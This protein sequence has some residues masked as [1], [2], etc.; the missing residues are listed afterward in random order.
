LDEKPVHQA[1]VSFAEVAAYEP[2]A[3]YKR[4]LPCLLGLLAHGPR[5]GVVIV[6]GFAWLDGGRSG[7]GAHLHAAVGGVV[8]G[9]AKT[10][11]AG[12][13]GVVEVLRGVSTTPLYVS[14]V[15]IGVDEAARHIAGMHGPHRLPTLLKQVDSLAR[16]A[17][18]AL[19]V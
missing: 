16:K 1:A 12:A 11:F 10:L 19:P 3:F 13:S 7:L 9:V 6:D 2:G 4:E 14:A 17:P 15:G 8:V 18:L 5:A